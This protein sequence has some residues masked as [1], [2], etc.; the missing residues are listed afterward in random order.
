MMRYPQGA[1]EAPIKGTQHSLGTLRRLSGRDDSKAE[2]QNMSTHNLAKLNGER[3]GG[4]TQIA[5]GLVGGGRE[6][7]RRPSGQRKEYTE[8]YNTKCYQNIRQLST[9]EIKLKK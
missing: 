5:K 4:V 8:K 7:W 3:A 1:S 6:G 9:L 2:Y